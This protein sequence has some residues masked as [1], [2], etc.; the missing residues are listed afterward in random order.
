MLEQEGRN[1]F[2]QVNCSRSGILL[3]IGCQKIDIPKIFLAQMDSC[4]NAKFI[5]NGTQ[6]LVLGDGPKRYIILPGRFVCQ[7]EYPAIRQFCQIYLVQTF[8]SIIYV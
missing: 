4:F 5:R 1:V 3:L 8:V 7:L 2:Q 6:N